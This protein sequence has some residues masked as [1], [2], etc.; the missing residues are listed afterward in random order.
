MS[1]LIHYVIDT[2]TS[3]L[4]TDMHELIEISVIR[5][6][7]KMQITRIVKADYPQN[8]SY[9][10]LKIT[11]KSV[12]DLY[13]GISKQQMVEEVNNFFDTDEKTPSHRCV[14]AHNASFDRRFLHTTWQKCNAFFPADLWLDTI[15]IGKQAAKKMNMPKAKMNLSAALDLFGIKKVGREHSAKGDSQNTYLLWKKFEEINEDFLPLIKSF[16]HQPP[17]QEDNDEDMNALLEDLDR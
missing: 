2:E 8:A 10:A 5:C 14:I 9:D 1:G 15:Q 17:P 7:D 3:G 16:P 6:S 11:N 4:S 12:R 13:N